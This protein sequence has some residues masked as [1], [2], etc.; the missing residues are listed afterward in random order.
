LPGSISGGYILAQR[1][2]VVEDD[3]NIRQVLKL[4]LEG[5]GYDVG[6]VEDGL[7]ALEE[8]SRNTPD[9]ILLD[10][11]MPK[12]D[13]YEVCR[14]LKADFETSRIPVIMLTAKSTP[15]EKVEGFECGANDYVTKPYIAKELLARVKAVLQWSRTQREANPLTGL[16]GNFSVEREA[17]D[18][19]N[20]RIPFAFAMCDIDNF[21]AFNDYYGYRRGDEAIKMTASIL[22]KAVEENGTGKD[23]VGHIGGD[24]F[25]YITSPQ[26]AELIG[27]QIATEFDQRVLFLYN[28]EDRSRGYLEVKNRR[29]E[30]ERFR[31][32]SITIVVIR[33]DSYVIDHVAKLSD[34]ASELKTYGKSLPGSVVVG[35]RRTE[36]L[37]AP[38]SKT[39]T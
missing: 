2:L 6:T 22:L 37:K 26:N 18:R 11:M 29:G 20:S 28:G 5:A 23:F 10:I 1:I 39:G 30:V 31:F 12:M 15:I 33:S 3:P 17:N 36:Q 9:L 27:Q 32:M 25:V 7:K 24:D 4:Q 34:I 38:T 19:I 8:V 35:E 16:P 13:G 21:K 14:R